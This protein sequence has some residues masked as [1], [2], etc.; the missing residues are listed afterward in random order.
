MIAFK[1]NLINRRL[2][3]K[4]NYDDIK[5]LSQMFECEFSNEQQ[6]NYFVYL[7]RNISAKQRFDYTEETDHLLM[8]RDD[9]KSEQ[10]RFIL[11]DKYKNNKIKPEIVLQIYLEEF[12]KNHSSPQFLHYHANK[13]II[14][15]I[16]AIFNANSPRI[17]TLD[18]LYHHIYTITHTIHRL[19]AKNKQ[20]DGN[21]YAAKID[22]K[23]MRIQNAIKNRNYQRL[24]I[25]FRLPKRTPNKQTRNVSQ[26]EIEYLR[27]IK[28]SIKIKKERD[29]VKTERIRS[30][31][32]MFSFGLR[33]KNIQQLDTNH[34]YPNKEET[35]AFWKS[36]FQNGRLVNYLEPYISDIA[37]NVAENKARVIITKSEV[38]E[39][40]R[41]ISNWKAPGI[42]K[43]NG[44]W[45]KYVDVCKHVLTN[46]FN[47][48]IDNP[49]TMPATM[50]E[51][52]TV[53][54][55]KGGETVEPKNYRPITCLNTILKVFTSVIKNK[56]E[57]QL[58]SNP[59][60]KQLTVNQL[61][62]KKLSYASKE[63]LIESVLMQSYL[64]RKQKKYCEL[65]IDV[66]KAYD[67]V[68][69]DWLLKCLAFYEIPQK[70][71]EVI[72]HM[73]KSWQLRLHYGSEEIS[74][75]KLENGILQGDSFSPL[76]FVLS[77]DWISKQLNY[78]IDKI[79]I[80]NGNNT[81][82]I[83]HIYYMDDLK[84]ITE[85]VDDMV[86]ANDILLRI[87]NAIG[88]KINDSKS[89]LLIKGNQ[90]IPEELL[91]YP[92]VSN[93]NPYKYLGVELGDKVNREQYVKRVV[94]NIESTIDRIVTQ[95]LS[96]MNII[97]QVNSD[98]ISKLRYGSSVVPW[99]M[100]DL[101]KL[102]NI[103]RRKLYEHGVYSKMMS[104]A[105]LYVPKERMG[106]GLMS[107]RSEYTKELFRVILKY[108][109]ESDSQ[110]NDLIEVTN[111]SPEGIWHRMVL[112]CKKYIKEE[113]IKQIISNRQNETSNRI[114]K[115]IDDMQKKF[116]AVHIAKWK[117]SKIGFA[118]KLEKN[119]IIA[120]P[121]ISA[122][123]T[124]NIKKEAYLQLLKIQEEA[125]CTGNRKAHILNNPNAKYCRY[126][127][128]TVCSISHILLGCPIT[129]KAQIQRH[130]AVC[131]QL[132]YAAYRKY[133][134]FDNNVWPKYIPRCTR[135]EEQNITILFNKEVLP[136]STGSYPKRPDLYIEEGGEI[137]YIIDVAIVKDDVVNKTYSNKVNKYLQL[138]Q[139]LHDEKG[140]KKTFIIP[141]ILSINGLIS[142]HSVRRLIEF[143]FNI[144]W[145]PIIRELLIT[146]MK[147]IMFYLNQHID[148]VELGTETPSDSTRQETQTGSVLQDEGL[149]SPS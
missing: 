90:I 50:T 39:A 146:Q 52:R 148:R 58:K 41:F 55:Y 120:D 64:N 126:C 75:V 104:S 101:D 27:Y 145:P 83:N 89:G 137:G 62:C 28:N 12:E 11:F 131:K 118:E 87:S 49:S 59:P 44:F 37:A 88:L 61:G 36:I 42:D 23:I 136:R 1:I 38:T 35:A 106:L 65:Y 133:K 80:P 63:G 122:W 107:C 142:K 105:R 130:D 29:R 17:S 7:S 34:Q 22:R 140:L 8:N 129:K 13:K 141:V 48:W 15:E 103:I 84:I 94:K 144:K 18:E 111:S 24:R 121:L 100:G 9:I 68:S 5:I 139:K 79:K 73:M 112:S 4:L 69:H 124:M 132:Y 3:Y 116:D 110:L 2:N 95:Q 93:N 70:L 149:T 113:E 45:L 21:T 123:R 76:L 56:I 119:D 97:R 96:T 92:I 128:N 74:S 143:E 51:G 98:I 66:E 57:K 86:K 102:D 43:V 114:N 33:K 31:A 20:Q 81:F 67:S 138:A 147:D 16:L 135:M 85:T 60:E 91:S 78:H 127:H 82:T 32:K 19:I 47:Q 40:I 134:Q 99:K 14:H 72:A 46:V 54:I 10:V 108:K 77:I 109:W 125:V 25:Q 71:N 117:K 53:L 26:A 30:N 115:A 6:Y